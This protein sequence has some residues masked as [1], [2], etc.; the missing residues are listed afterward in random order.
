MSCLVMF[1][2]LYHFFMMSF[3][4]LSM[5]ADGSFLTI[6]VL[7]FPKDSSILFMY[8]F[9]LS[10][11][12]LFLL[13]AHVK[14]ISKLLWQ[15]FFVYFIKDDNFS[16]VVFFCDFMCKSLWNWGMIVFLILVWFSKWKRFMLLS[17]SFINSY[18]AIFVLTGKLN[19]FPN[20][21]KF[22]TYVGM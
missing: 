9:L 12:V 5:D 2:S 10:A 22:E 21:N 19:F 8:M 18:I 17:M 20:C 6:Y 7:V 13:S 16:L 11:T 14:M 3:N 4:F 1:S 15:K